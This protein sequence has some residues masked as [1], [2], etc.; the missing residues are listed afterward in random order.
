MTVDLICADARE[1][2]AAMPEGSVDAVVTDPPYGLGFMGKEWDSAFIAQRVARK[3]RK[4]TDI[5]PGHGRIESGGFIKYDR[6][7]NG[8][9]SFQEW[10]HAWAVEA[11]RVLKPG[12]HLLAFGGTRTHHRLWCAV[13]DAGFEIR[14]SIGFLGMLGWV[15]GSGF[16]KSLNLE[17][18]WEGWGTALKP[19]WEPIVLARKPLS[20]TVAA[21]VQEHGAGALNVDG[22]RIPGNWKWGT[23]TDIRGGGYGTRRPSE[24]DVLA[25]DLESDP[26]GRWPANLVLDEDAAAMLDAQSGETVAGKPRV[27]RGSGGIWAD[28][29]GIPCGPQYGDSGGASR[30]FYCAKASREEREAGVRGEEKPLRW[31]SGGKNPGSFQADGTKRSAR[32]NHPTVKPI[33]LMRWLV[34]LVTSPGGTILDPFIGSGTTAVAAVLEGFHCIGI[35]NNAEYLKTARDRVDRAI[36]ER[37]HG[38]KVQADAV[39]A[40]QGT[41]WETLAH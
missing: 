7:L 25:R 20:G 10:C 23:Q 41:P 13:E 11:L 29:D 16:P 34:R 9:R 22:C 8:N 31:F 4:S 2:L 14:D 5:P 33:D 39:E 40:G 6:S 3:A 26:A 35:D 24:G 15:Y 27:D 1:A 19:A 30:F 18:E 36:L 12:G 38:G 21:N 32:N 37:E 28:G 17:G